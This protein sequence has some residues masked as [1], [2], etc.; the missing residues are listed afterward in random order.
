MTSCNLSKICL[1]GITRLQNT[2]EHSIPSKQKS[3]MSSMG[4]PL[5]TLSNIF[6]TSRTYLNE[7][8]QKMLLQ[9]VSKKAAPCY[10]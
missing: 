1:I 3:K 4:I 10:F 6:T 9:G 5:Q 2:T 7:E 8:N